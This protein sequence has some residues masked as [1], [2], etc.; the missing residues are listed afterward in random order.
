M[1]ISK[2]YDFKTAEAKWQKWWKENDIFRYDSSAEGEIFS[3]DTPPPTV[4]GKL[5]IGHVFSYTH[6]DII[7]RYMRLKG[8][9]V[10]YPLG[11]DDNGLPTEML[12]ERE[13][14]LRGESLSR[15]EFTKLCMDTADKY[16]GLFQELFESL[17]FSVAW[18]TSYHTISEKSRRISQRSFLDLLKKELVYRREMPTLWCTKCKTAFAQAEIEDINKAGM[19]NYLNFEVNGQPVLPIATT[20][21]ELLSSCVAI[22]VHPENPKFAGMIGQEAK[23]P[24]FGQMVP[25]IGD[26]KADPEKGTGVVMCCTF[27]D[28]TD[29]QWW[30]EYNLPL[31]ISFNDDGTMNERAGEYAGLTI[32]AAKAAIIERLKEEGLIFRQ[33]EIPA[34]NRAVNTHERCGTEVE[35]LVKNQWFVSIVSR[36]DELIR[37]GEKVNWYPSH[38]L[39]RYRHWVE[40]LSWDWAVSRQRFFGIPIPVWYCSQC[41]EI[42]IPREQDLPVNPIT[43]RPHENCSCGCGDFIAETDVLDTWA[44][45]SCTPQLNSRWGEEDERD[46]PFPMSMRPQAHDIIRTWAFYTIVKST[47]H[48]DCIPWENAVI[49]GHTVKRGQEAARGGDG[50]TVAGKDY[51]RKSKI[52]K[53][54]DGDRFSPQRLIE[55]Y[56]ADAI[57]YWTSSGKLG[58]DVV[59]DE[60]EVVETNR[61]LT[62]LWNSAR[63]TL[64][65]IDGYSPEDSAVPELTTID[66]WILGRMVKT[67]ES[68]HRYFAEFEFFPARIELQSFFWHD[69]CDNYI[70]IVKNRFRD[71]STADDVARESARYTL[72]NVLLTILKLYTPFIPHVTE[73]IFSLYF[74]DIEGHKSIH[75]TTFPQ[76]ELYPVEETAL[77]AGTVMSELVR[78]VR[79]YK[80]KA[81]LSL[82]LPIAN[83]WIAC[84]DSGQALVKSLSV[85]LAAVAVANNIV[86]CEQLP[87]QAEEHCLPETLELGERHFTVAL[88]MDQ[89][90]LRGARLASAVKKAVTAV[91]KENG[92]NAKDGVARVIL[93]ASGEIADILNRE[94][95][96]IIYNCTAGEVEITTAPHLT[97][98]DFEAAIEV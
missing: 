64:N 15:E 20:R 46:I 47:Y 94:K 57:R 19:F 85:D 67:L 18:E 21:P 16:C 90:A 7:A 25:I 92:L 98:E 62:K 32:K 50:A 96:R 11:F 38:M 73:E 95:S 91:K 43:D 9:K 10:F 13:H 37:Q 82:M 42:K 39:T 6:T 88:E 23:V 22:F 12:T 86:I 26:I 69:F 33:E 97:G 3:I 60:T 28:T 89:E 61:L 36:K 87:S 58:T 76:T 53:S 54:K 52:S 29:I 2:N 68:Y 78:M 48:S 24:L 49:S 65:L 27:G 4:S 79:G 59:F 55:E 41:G 77:Q 72:Y 30:R 63:F 56:S 35:Y 44:T 17:G 81:Q 40:N 45:S 14:G 71:D 83:L 70:E 8:R 1:E 31:R 93:S 66:K 80:T 34:E 75:Q 74:A 5:H 51:A 84:D